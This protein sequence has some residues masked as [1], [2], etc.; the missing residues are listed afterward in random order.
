MSTPSSKTAGA[1][2]D[3][4]STWRGLALI[5]ALVTLAVCGNSIGRTHAQQKP[6][7]PPAYV[8]PI[9]WGKQKGVKKYRLQIAG[10][11]AFNDVRFDG[12]VIGER[13]LVRDFP[14]GRYYW[15]IAPSSSQPRPFHRPA[16]FIVPGN[17]SVV[18]KIGE[19][20]DKVI[21]N[22]D[23]G[24]LAATGDVAAPMR[25]SLATGSEAH[26]IGVNS[27]GTVYALNGS[28]G[29]ALW[30][31]RYR[32]SP[33][34]KTAASFQ[35]FRPLISK[36]RNGPSVV[37]IVIVA[38]DGGVR[39][40]KGATGQQ[41]W[42]A[43]LP[44]NATSGVVSE[45]SLPTRKVYL[46]ID[47]LQR[48]SSLVVMDASSG[49]IETQTKLAGQ[50][51]N[52]VVGSPILF[53]NNS[54]PSLLVALRDGVIAVYDAAGQLIRS[55]STGA[56]VTAG[57]VIVESLRRK[58]ILVGTS[59][60]LAAFTAETDIADLKFLRYIG[61]GEGQQVR[62]L[63]AADVEG[64][65]IS[66]VV[67][68]TNNSGTNSGGTNGGRVSLVDPDQMQ[69]RWSV[70]SSIVGAEIGG[71]AVADM[72]NDGRL[73]VLLPGKDDFA[74][75][76]SGSN[77]SV[78]W[79]SHLPVATRAPVQT[80]AQLRSFA[81]TT[82]RTGRLMLVGSDVAAGGLRAIEIIPATVI[83]NVR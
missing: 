62:S 24:W 82:L 80:K 3:F 39:A 14:P 37:P 25:T 35:P 68:V 64:N 2:P 47:N 65:R 38:Y 50:V 40:L 31:A 18:N 10:D 77:G 81:V 72:N 44:G 75:A 61:L 20:V 76:L 5:V 9:H 46:I 49:R 60:G 19:R 8:T 12:P 22:V 53:G 4:G 7:V 54:R 69:I 23:S 41:V 43:D 63:T 59:K 56:E 74:L 17:I 66:E 48:G 52:S 70:D 78:I 73:D 51:V 33:L 71:A 55:I 36:A 26:F 83:S 42:R 34:A 1:F 45:A 79:K 27:E 15:R 28:T 11:E 29:V 32:S 16:Y 13:Y 6:L 58:L 21:P 67:A 57:P 30:T